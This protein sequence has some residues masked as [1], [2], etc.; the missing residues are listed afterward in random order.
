L[1]A[2]FDGGVDAWIEQIGNHQR[3][4]SREEAPY[5]AEVVLQGAQAAAGAG[6][7]TAQDLKD[8]YA[9]GSDQFRELHRRWLALPSQH[10][11]LTFE[12]LLLSVGIETVPLDPWLVEFASKAVGQPVDGPAALT[13]VADTA[14]AMQVTP[15]RLRNAIWQYQTKLDQR[16]HTSP[17]G[18]NRVAAGAA[19]NEAL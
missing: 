5:K 15:F 17:A 18:S 6:V 19:A 14:G 16:E 7:N 4:Y 13:L 12:R 8:G 2:T 9:R 10:S 11:G 1:I 3:A